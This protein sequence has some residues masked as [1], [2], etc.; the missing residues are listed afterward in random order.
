M[1]VNY[2]PKKVK[3]P[4]YDFAWDKDNKKVKKIKQM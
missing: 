4:R 1:K 2:N 3:N